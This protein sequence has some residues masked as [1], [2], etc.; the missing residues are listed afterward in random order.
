MHLCRKGLLNLLAVGDTT[1]AY[2][3]FNFG[4]SSIIQMARLK[5]SGICR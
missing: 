2:F 3:L 1:Y 4:G 5:N